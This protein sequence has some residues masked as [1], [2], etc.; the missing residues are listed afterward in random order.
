MDSKEPI[1]AIYRERDDGDWE[2]FAAVNVEELKS[3]ATEFN[4]EAKATEM[5]NMLEQLEK[6]TSFKLIKFPEPNMPSVYDGNA[7]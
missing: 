5:L 1:H 7:P 6:A 2:F 4:L 3:L